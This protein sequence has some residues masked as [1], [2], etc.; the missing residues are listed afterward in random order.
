MSNYIDVDIL[1]NGKPIKKFAHKGQVYIQS[2]HDTE[3]SIRLKNSSWY[4]RLV[5]ITVD[6]I[7]VIDG[8]AG[9]SSKNGYLINGYS[10]I[11]IKGFRTDNDTV[12]P[13]I[14]SAKRHSYAKKS[15][16]TGGDTTNCGV[17]GVQVYSE[18]TPPVTRLELFPSTPWNTPHWGTPRG[19]V[20]G[21]DVGTYSNTLNSS[22]PTRSASSRRITSNAGP[23]YSASTSSIS[24]DSLDDEPIACACAGASMGVEQ[25][26]SIIA[27]TPKMMNHDMGTE[28]SDKSVHDS[29]VEVEFQVGTLLETIVI[30]YGS[31]KSL[32]DIGVPV[33]YQK[34]IASVPN[35][36]P[37]K[38]CKP[39]RR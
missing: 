23:T 26:R 28:F 11:D 4:R 39:P 19:P 24:A 33:A 12:H 36:F 15:D 31:R 21:D 17:I 3:Y 27:D 6:G 30:H 29:V 16:A 34:Q 5:V 37:S 8:Q 14:F 35:P 9:G 22:G 10:S 38:F 18:Y 1:V 32:M 2:N 13:F 25:E 7:N 20:F